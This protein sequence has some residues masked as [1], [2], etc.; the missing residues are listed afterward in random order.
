MADLWVLSFAESVKKMAEELAAQKEEQDK[1]EEKTDEV[2][3]EETLVSKKTDDVTS[4]D[5]QENNDEQEK[6]KTLEEISKELEQ[7][8]KKE[9]LMS[10]I[11]ETIGDKLETIV[12]SKNPQQ[13]LEEMAQQFYSMYDAL[14]SEKIRLEVWYKKLEEAYVKLAAEYE[15]LR[16]TVRQWWDIDEDVRYMS[17]LK[18][19]DQDEYVDKSLSEVSKIYQI[20]EDQLKRTIKEQRM[21][22]IQS[23]NWTTPEIKT[24][25]KQEE[26][27]E[28][29]PLFA[30][31]K[32]SKVRK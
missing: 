17:K 18:K 28:E 14:A 3:T 13:V 12:E 32:I 24:E 6:P 31:F 25:P 5:S 27:Q 2:D 30:W 19:L 4:D 21:A 1:P 8:E 23:M 29:Q 26:K 16:I 10:D 9:E 20:P 15:N 22:A 11:K 7:Q